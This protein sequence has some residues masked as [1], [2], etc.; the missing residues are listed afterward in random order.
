MW[1]GSSP[2][3][4]VNGAAGM[5]IIALVIA[6]LH[7]AEH[8]LIPLALAGF[9]SFILQPLV[10]W[11]DDYR[12]PRSLA[13]LTVVVMTTLLLGVASLFLA[14]EVSTLAAELPRHETNLREKA[15][16]AADALNSFGV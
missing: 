11:L 1:P 13:V 9:L 14:R 8:F 7:F 2:S 10:Q 6:A 12:W 4:L 15:R 3:N 5:T 16:T